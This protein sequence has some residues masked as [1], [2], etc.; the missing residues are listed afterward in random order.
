MK[1]IVEDPFVPE[2]IREPK[3]F[4]SSL[5]ETLFTPLDTREFR[6]ESSIYN[7]TA[8]PTKQPQ[9]NLQPNWLPQIHQIPMK[10]PLRKLQLRFQSLTAHQMNSK[11]RS[12]KHPAL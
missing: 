5:D 12:P 8:Q 11:H 1:K 9:P 10:Y 4:D 7:K 3:L 2:K 6:I